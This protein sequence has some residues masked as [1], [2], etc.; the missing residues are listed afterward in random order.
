M[1]KAT[2]FTTT[3]ALTAVLIALLIPV[4]AMSSRADEAANDQTKADPDKGR[5]RSILR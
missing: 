5:P 2:R 4:T 3:I 1:K